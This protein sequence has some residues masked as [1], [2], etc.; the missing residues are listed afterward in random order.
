MH[1]LAMRYNN[2][3]ASDMIN[4]ITVHRFW[5]L[6]W[7]RIRNRVDALGLYSRP[8]R[9]M[10]VVQK[11]L[12]IP[13]YPQKEP[14][15]ERMFFCKAK[16]L[17]RKIGFDLIV[18]EYHGLETLMAGCKMNRLYPGLKHLAILWDP[19]K[20][21]I[22][23]SYLPKSFTD[24]RIDR[25]ERFVAGYT[26][27]QISTASMREY[28]IQNGDVAQNRRIY[29]DIPSI[30]APGPE[31]RTGYL[32]LFREGW[33][34]IVYSG[35]LSPAQRDPVPFINLLNQCRDAERINLLFFSMGA[36]EE[37]KKA[38]E[39]FR[40]S[41]VRHGYIPLNE[42]HTLYMH[43]DYLLNVS[44]IN[45]NM[46]PS[47]IFEYMSYGKPVISTYI[48]DNDSAKNYLSRYPEGLCL[49]LKK[50]K[51]D[52]VAALNDFFAA[53][54]VQVPYQDVKATFAANTPD[55]YLATIDK[56]LSDN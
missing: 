23:T 7:K 47:K 20:G 10:E 50:P 22:A 1:V 11:A 43:A 19:V 48:S 8:A 12:T 44:H 51:A 56:L 49:D 6:P 25:V 4:G 41:I 55:T 45:A 3:R 32:A 31:V 39:S 17:H 27:L 33:I 38:E 36:D 52:N 28:H 42:L 13:A 18:S 16:A 5:P 24:K 37:L 53:G 15:T 46:V 9:M 54:H 40:G 14:F 35:L 2:E 29:L 26:T 30:I 21:Q 34:N